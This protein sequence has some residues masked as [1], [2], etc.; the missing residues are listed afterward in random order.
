VVPVVVLNETTRTGL[1]ART[2]AMLAAKRWRTTGV[3][4]FIG[5]VHDTT[6]YFPAGR[7]HDAHRL[8]K[9]LPGRPNRTRPTFAGIPQARLV[10]VLTATYPGR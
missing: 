4:N 7:A 3:G 2:S 8:A 9:A 5:T 10:V 6:V 1:A